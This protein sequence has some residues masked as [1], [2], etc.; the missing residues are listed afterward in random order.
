LQI[1]RLELA[2]FKSFMNPVALEF[3]GGI[4]AILGPNGCGK[5]NVVDA[6]RWVLGEQSAKQ[7]RGEKMMNV[8]FNGTRTRKPL[9]MAEVAVS[10][11]NNQGRLPVA[12]D[13]VKLTRRLTRDGQSDYLLNGAPCRLKD[14]KD[15]ITDTGAGSHGYAIIEREQVDGV[16]NGH[17]D[18]RRFLFEEASGIMKYRL[19]RK[20]AQ[21]KLELTEQDLLRLHDI[22]EEIA[23]QVRSLRRQMGRARRYQD[24]QEKL[25]RAE[26][27]LAQR[28]LQEYRGEDASLEAQ[29]AD[30]H[31]ADAGEDAAGDAAQAHIETLR[32]GM[33]ET[34][35]AYRAAGAACD[36][37]ARMLKGS[38]D[39]MLVLRE[40]IESTRESQAAATTEVL[41]TDQRLAQVRVDRERLELQRQELA[42]RLEM[43]R[44]A[45][46]ARKD[47]LEA[48]EVRHQEARSAVLEVK[49]RSFDF[50]QDS[51]ASRN[52]LA[53]LRAKLEAQALRAR[54]LQA[55]LDVEAA[56][57]ERLAGEHAVLGQRIEVSDRALE[58]RRAALAAAEGRVEQVGERLETRREERSDLQS[59]LEATRSRHELLQALVAAYD[60]YG[61]GARSLLQHHGGDG[62]RV[63]GA[64]VE[65][66]TPPPG[67][68]TAFD[69]L[70]HDVV[71]ALVV[72]DGRAAV[73]L[74]QHL[75]GARLGR[76][77]LVPPAAAPLVEPPAVRALAQQ[78][79]VLGLAA[80]LLPTDGGQAPLLRRL[81]MGAVVV[82]DAAV[83]QRLLDGWH[84]PGLRIA[85]R[86][87]LVF[88]ASGAVRGGSER[89]R[90]VRL[91]GRRHRLAE[92]EEELGVVGGEMHRV[93]ASLGALEAELAAARQ[94]RLETDAA[95]RAEEEQRQELLVQ[96]AG[97]ETSIAE[98]TA[99]RGQMAV[100]HEQVQTDAATLAAR[101]PELALHAEQLGREADVQRDALGAREQ[102]LADL[103][104]ERDRLRHEVGEMRVAFVTLQGEG[105]SVHRQLERL[106]ELE[107]ELGELGARRREE[108]ARAERDLERYACELAA[109]TERGA[110]LAQQLEAA[111]A[112]RDEVG[113]RLDGERSALDAE[114]ERLHEIEKARR[115]QDARRHHLE[116]ALAACRLRRQNLLDRIT[117]HYALGEADLLA[118]QFA[119]T[120]EDP[121]PD[122]AVLRSLR[123]EIARLGPVNLLAL[124]EHEEKSQ[125]LRFLEEQRDDLTRASAS[126]HETIDK[127]NRTARFLFLETF[128][129]I[130][131][132]FR[133]TIRT[134]FDGGEGDLVLSHP[135]D[136]LESDIEILVRPRG[137]KIDTLTQLSSGERALTAIAL[138][139]SI[140]LVKPSPFCVFD[141]VDAPLDDA[142]IGRFV[143]LL[144]EF[145]DR[146]Q[147][148]VITHNKLTMEA[149]DRLYG[150]TMEE[151][152][153]SKLVSVALDGEVKGVPRALRK[154]TERKAR[155]AALLAPAAEALA[156]L[157]AAALAGTGGE[158]RAAR[159]AARLDR[160]GVS[161][162]QPA[163]GLDLGAELA[164]APAPEPA[165][166]ALLDEPAGGNGRG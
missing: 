111:H 73:E 130:R 39:S 28:R 166:T 61:E 16:I 155:A 90:D 125:R 163:A 110:S 14:I 127:I 11:V 92:L 147:F 107:R 133:D 15:L 33:L 156:G 72:Q 38:E 12:F 138:L 78:E 34:E 76:A 122:D 128:E 56:R 158:E 20:E 98:A 57:I 105:E 10:F 25:R 120:D 136:P 13:E 88:D 126:L 144:Q 95:V 82:E 101:I 85:T 94:Q 67:L 153:V 115:E 99:R 46:R 58:E 93:V 55:D 17:E 164:A 69:A 3:G 83:A 81:L 62:G 112:A 97:L 23:R 2:G 162:R 114:Q 106:G 143:N 96:R 49:Q 27:W 4:T 117:E 109:A 59:R 54:E 113:L 60:G 22:I 18:A 134:V 45:F 29:L 32:L 145:K 63:L 135:D 30:L 71:D 86:D 6:M 8:V 65:H 64:L 47:E 1:K 68:E 37:L 154:R 165:A 74:L 44:D 149:A 146:T 150:V 129:Q 40:R 100:V 140:Y 108:I 48:C 77:T 89:D 102:L 24:L 152:G 87:G 160:N 36:D 31:V 139:F 159:P 26:T 157:D 151:E 52:E 43:E 66:V 103:D 5:S 79:G 35:R 51:A 91:L 118:L 132:H 141:E 80:E 123:D 119:W 148:I 75:R 116:M 104:R 42:R 9:G 53:L 131:G 161:S 121:V 7:L 70:L 137:K 21:R 50:A 19:R 142:N 41:V 124:E 84:A